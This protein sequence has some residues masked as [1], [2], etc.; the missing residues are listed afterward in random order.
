MYSNYN[1]W[2]SWSFDN[3]PYILRPSKDSVYKFHVNLQ[4]DLVVD[5]YY[6]ELYN[7]AAAMRDTF[8]GKFDV[9][10]SG[11]IDSEVVVRTF[12]DLGIEHNT[13]IFKY[14]D[15]YNYRDVESAI[16]L[17]TCLNIPFKVIDFSLKKFYENEAYELFQKSKCIRAGRLPH[18]KFPDY[19]D[20]IPVMGD[21][22]PY[23]KLT[24]NKW[25]LPIGEGNHAC[26]M[27]LHSQ[28]RENICDWY[29]FKPELLKSFNELPII[30]DLI[31]NRLHGKQ[32][33]WSSRLPI[34]RVLW[35]DMQVKEKLVGFEVDG[36]PGTQP[37]FIKDL[38][39]IMTNEIGDGTEYW[40]TYEEV[41]QSLFSLN[42]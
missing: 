19:L 35:P 15:N 27:Y 30:Q 3:V 23:W 16:E 38:Q 9:M 40:L 14:E 39:A 42:H 31:N 32:S 41:N 8:S 34:H 2:L 17:A 36:A 1:G 4:S 37:A 33:S 21:A 28:G 25:V 24:N 20:N 6:K 22:E 26:S 29:E 10:L 11:G 13:F 7:N 5:S 12:K 18:V